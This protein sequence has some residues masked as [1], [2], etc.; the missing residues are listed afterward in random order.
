VRAQARAPNA[1]AGAWTV[2]SKV[3]LPYPRTVHSFHLLS[4][5]FPFH[6]NATGH[7]PKENIVERRSSAEG[8]VASTSKRLYM[9][10]PSCAGSPQHVNYGGFD[11]DTSAEASAVVPPLLHEAMSGVENPTSGH[12][13]YPASPDTRCTNS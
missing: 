5:G 7:L 9:P 4:S 12:T 11:L 8:C 6:F 13:E 10:P 3:D 1:R 2:R